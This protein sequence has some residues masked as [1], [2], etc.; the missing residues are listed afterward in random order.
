V[1]QPLS[2]RG[3]I[4]R[5]VLVQIGFIG[6]L[7]PGELLDHPSVYAGLRIWRTSTN[8]SHKLFAPEPF[9]SECRAYH[10]GGNRVRGYMTARIR[11]ERNLVLMTLLAHIKKKECRE[12]R[13][14]NPRCVER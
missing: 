12:R 10:F 4:I 9:C 1:N 7:S 13:K 5:K 6:A 3:R 14:E 2:Q 11:D 8:H